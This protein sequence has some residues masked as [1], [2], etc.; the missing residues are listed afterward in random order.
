M[1]DCGESI[2]DAITRGE[3]AAPEHLEE[4]ARP[5]PGVCCCVVIIVPTDEVVFIAGLVLAKNDAD[6]VV[7]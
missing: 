4:S 3:R 7:I 1:R 6:R 5:L 2:R